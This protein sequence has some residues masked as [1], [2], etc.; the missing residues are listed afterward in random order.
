MEILQKFE[1]DSRQQVNV[2]K[3]SVF[4][5]STEIRKRIY[6]CQAL[7]MQEANAQITYLGLP[8]TIGR[9]KGVILGFLKE[10]RRKRVQ[11]WD[12][13]LLSWAG[14]EI[15]IKTVVQSLPS[16]ATIVFLLP[17]EVCRDMEK[18]YE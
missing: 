18:S 9:N 4:F 2:A 16:Y 5:S 12:G 17:P 8:N 13:K 15:L 6:V 10:R 3:S 14:K 7:G 1:S 11:S